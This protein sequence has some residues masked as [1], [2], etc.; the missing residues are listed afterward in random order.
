M[1]QVHV[2]DA[3]AGAALELRRK[4]KTL[5]SVTTDDLGG[6]LFRNV[7]AGSGFTVV[8]P[9]PPRR[10]SAPVTVLSADELPPQCSTTTSS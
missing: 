5:Q 2:I 1:H 3:P 10:E 6:Y 8:Q 4:G 7:D 9:G